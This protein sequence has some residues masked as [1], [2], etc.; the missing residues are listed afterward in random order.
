MI[1]HISWIGVVSVGKVFRC[2]A[3][4]PANV[5]VGCYGSVD[6]GGVAGIVCDSSGIAHPDDVDDEEEAAEYVPALAVGLGQRPVLHILVIKLLLGL[7][8][9]HYKNKFYSD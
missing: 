1:D 9:T 8:V 2:V 4:I 6:L 7:F 3:G 5:S